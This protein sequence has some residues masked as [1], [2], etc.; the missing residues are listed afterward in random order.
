MIPDAYLTAFEADPLAL[1]FARH[2]DAQVASLCLAARAVGCPV[3][4]LF[5]P[6]EG[7]RDRRGWWLRIGLPLGVAYCQQGRILVGAAG[8]PLADC[9]FV[10]AACRPLIIDKMATKIALGVLGVPT[11]AGRA[12]GYGE[13]EAA[14]DYAL[15]RRRPVC[16]KPV[17][18]SLGAGVFPDLSDRPLIRTALERLGRR[19]RRIL[20]EDHA[21]GEAVRFI[22]V[23][24]RVVGIR[25]DHPANVEGDGVSTIAQL[26]S[27]KNRIKRH[28][29]G[30]KA[31]RIGADEARLLAAQGLTRT[32][33]P[34]NG[35][36]VFLRRASNA[37]LGGDSHVPPD[38]LHPGYAREVERLCLGIPGLRIVAVDTLIR[39]PERPPSPEGYNVLELNASPG[40]VQF[41]FPWEGKPLDLAPLVIESLIAENEA[42]NGR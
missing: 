41:R 10:N 42:S 40:M 19:R 35:R 34:E 11:P 21:P 30:Q 38:G 27:A 24:P 28:R 18:G 20:V 8:A 23:H 1:E 5:Q 4:R 31:V 17:D 13:I 33:I 39:W 15:S 9:R 14:Q 16:L 7:G 32:S 26:L 29:T 37:S 36:R 25:L 2:G 12:F 6:S 22:F 3:H